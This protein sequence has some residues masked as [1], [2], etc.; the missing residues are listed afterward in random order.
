MP[1]TGDGALVGGAAVRPWTRPV[2]TS[3]H[4]LGRSILVD[5]P[6]ALHEVTCVSVV[7]FDDAG[8]LDL[9]VLGLELVRQGGWIGVPA[10]PDPRVV[11]SLG[12]D[13][14]RVGPLPVADPG[15]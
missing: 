10:A 6:L 12:Q 2:S 1:N 13:Q 4:R 3:S 14:V 15:I 7:E 8:H 9:A 5:P 11:L